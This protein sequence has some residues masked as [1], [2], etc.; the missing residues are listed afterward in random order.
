MFIIGVSP[1]ARN[2]CT[3]CKARSLEWALLPTAFQICLLHLGFDLDDFN[4]NYLDNTT[5]V[6]TESFS[7][8]F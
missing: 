2:F 1:K 3:S 8:C 7:I 6:N 4:L 5:N